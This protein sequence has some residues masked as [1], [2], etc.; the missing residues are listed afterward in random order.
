MG[1][2]CIIFSTFLYLK[3]CLMKS[4]I[5]TYPKHTHFS[6]ASKFFQM[7]EQSLWLAQMQLGPKSIGHP[8]LW[9]LRASASHF[10]VL[11]SLQRPQ[12]AL[13]ERSEAPSPVSLQTESRSVPTGA[14]RPSW[15]SA[16]LPRE[17]E[18]TCGFMFSCFSHVGLSATPWTVACQDPLSMGIHQTRILEWVAMSSSRG[19]S[20]PRDRTQVSHIA[21]RF[22]ITWATREAQEY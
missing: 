8:S 1:F 14:Q 11:S 7:W 9:L 22:F 12:C 4:E 6:C 19:S 3:I 21:G 2:H 18:S 15:V 10:C 17:A 20:Q 13:M 5:K 16:P